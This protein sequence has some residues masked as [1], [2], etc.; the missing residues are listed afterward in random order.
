[1]PDVEPL[2]F[3]S[4]E[5][6]PTEQ[7]HDQAELE[8][9]TGRR[10]TCVLLNSPLPCVDK[11]IYH[12]QELKATVENWCQQS[13][14]Y[15][16]KQ[17]QDKHQYNKTL[18]FPFRESDNEFMA[19]LFIEGI[20]ISARESCPLSPLLKKIYDVLG[21]VVYLIEWLE[22]D[23]Q[24]AEESLHKEK[25]RKRF[26][27]NK[28]DSISQWKQQEHS[29]VVQKE[30][31]AC[32]RDLSELKW[33]LKQERGKLDQAQDQLS[34]TEM[35]N[36]R[37]HEDVSFAKKQIP[38]VTENFNFQRD[39]VKQ[40]SAAQAEV[41][42]VHS[43]TQSDLTLV[44]DELDK[45]ELDAKNEKESLEHEL[46]MTKNQLTNKLDDLNQLKIQEEG[47][48]TE[49]K[50]AEKTVVHA[51]ERCAAARQRVTEIQELEKT[52]ADRILH[53]KLQIEDGIQRNKKLKEKLIAL[54][55]DIEKTRLTGKAE[56]SRIEE[57]LNLKGNAFTAF[58]KENMEYKQS[59]EDNNTKLYQSKKKVK[60]IHEERK[61]ML[62]KISDNAEQVGKAKEE[63]TQV[64]ARHSVV[65]NKLEMQE[66][67]TFTE[68]QRAR[69]EIEN[70]RKHLTGQVNDL[71]LLK[72]QCANINE[73]FQ[74]QQRSSKLTNQKLQKEFEH[75]LSAQKALETKVKKIKE[76]T[77]NLEK[78]QCEH[79]NTL[80]NLNKERKLKCDYLKAAQNV[81]T[82][83]IKRHDDTVGKIRDLTKKSDEYRAA[84]DQME[85]LAESMPEVI[86]ELQS[87][88]DVAQFKAQSAAL[89]MSTL[90]SDINNYQ[91]RTQRSMQTHTAHVTAKEKELEDTQE[92][93]KV[94][95]KQNKELASRYEGLQKILMEAKKE[96]VSALNEKIR[97]HE[98]FL[99]YTKL[100]LLQKRMHKALVKY[101]KQPSFYSQAELDWCQGLSQETNQKIK[102]A[103]T[104]Q[105]AAMS[106]WPS[107]RRPQ[108]ITAQGREEYGTVGGG[109]IREL[110]SVKDK[111][112]GVFKRTTPSPVTAQHRVTAPLSPCSLHRI[113][114]H[115]CCHPEGRCITL[116]RLC[117]SSPLSHQPPK[118]PPV[119]PSTI[120]G[121]HYSPSPSSPDSPSGSCNIYTKDLLPIEVDMGLI[122]LEILL[123]SDDPPL[124]LS[125]TPTRTPSFCTLQQLTTINALQS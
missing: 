102:T 34:H 115:A 116:G 25:K 3:P 94:A 88:F 112:A 9:C 1:M 13:G 99:Y 49:I 125:P 72:D 32:I 64:M 8:A 89:V 110:Q 18:R 85:K 21:E 43:Q 4:R 10:R 28:V 65:Q 105:G 35:L 26:L 122:S 5:G 62:Q 100:S 24:H 124:P 7:D 93:L 38:S 78:I 42:L 46:M 68:E 27:E 17:D 77:E 86:A 108:Q 37:L 69:E 117:N 83:T 98:C 45:M 90:Q 81:H 123:L 111:R 75:V 119:A 11:A 101:F 36:Q 96:A 104:L 82:A 113:P 16:K 22:A 48:C 50:D 44:Q 40:I 23:R 91:R 87:V 59:I 6:R 33:K 66:R 2:R 84:A 31:E 95:L 120:P 107:L 53:L 71:E 118:P 51:E 56:V 74:Q 97:R 92:A 103:Q 114:L 52:E 12:I 63:M 109:A 55:E 76:L 80:V 58:H 57:Q 15:R 47:L 60:Q 121:V 14:K 79:R 61:Q 41:D 20:S 30:H 67:L 73:E 29:V 106:H 19:E 54:Q 70:L 39:V